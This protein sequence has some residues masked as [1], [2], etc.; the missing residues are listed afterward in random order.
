MPRPIVVGV[1]GSHESLAAADWAARE[2]LRRGLP[3]RLLYADEELGTGSGPPESDAS[4]YWADKVLRAAADRIEECLPQV[5]LS[6][7]RVARPAAEALVAAGSRAELLVVGSR[8][9]GGIGGF[10]AG[11]VASA[12]VARADRPVVLVRADRPPV[13]G[14]GVP[15]VS[16]PGVG[17]P[18]VVGVDAEQPCEEVPAFAFDAAARRGSQL[19]VVAGWQL[20]LAVRPAPEAV[21][22]AQQQDTE[23]AV[24]RIL[25]PWRAQYPAVVVRV[26]VVQGHPAQELLRTSR[27]AALLVVG[28]RIRAP[29]LL[30]HT[31][32]VTHAMI[33]H[34]RCPV[35]VVPHR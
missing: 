17:R 29:R 22:A 16:D 15:D 14:P 28:R 8:A 26:L 30:P 32:P 10:M 21:T 11:S 24:A 33:H 3:L 25:D 23:R 35:A 6:T 5:P 31:G 12:T 7:E 9:F 19:W 20:P 4:R 13:D 27:E 18:V 34:A 2:A 1:D